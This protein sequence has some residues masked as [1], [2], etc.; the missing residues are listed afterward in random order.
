[1]VRRL[2]IVAGV[3][4][5]ASIGC[6]TTGT[7]VGGPHNEEAAAGE[8]PGVQAPKPAERLTVAAVQ[9]RSTPDLDANV[10]RTIEFIARCAEHG[11]R[12]V[13]FP[14]CNVTM[15][16]TETATGATAEELA[17]AERRIGEA[18]REHNV[19]AIVGMPWRDGGKLFNSAIILGPDGG[20]I[21]RYHKVQLAED[22]P[23]PGDHL[24]IY[25]IDGVWCTTIVCHD[26]RYP[27]L[28]RLPVLCGARVVFYISH[29]SGIKKESKIGPYRA[30]IQARA[31]E[32]TVYVI[33][34]NA[35]A[36]EDVSGSNGHS[37]IIAPDG[38]MVQEASV[39]GEDVLIAELDLSRATGSLAQKS[40]RSDLLRHWWEA[41]MQHVRRVEPAAAP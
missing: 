5:G 13:V 29:E 11:A 39:F 10:A 35:P 6:S 32:N 26:E 27:E 31:V 30:Q 37:R 9:M 24:S 34:A 2:L 8:R 17:G 19:Y 40:L 23:D 1:M 25:P 38:N 33:Q 16:A 15:Y 41:G 12:V 18:C 36:N 4:V 3:V 28:V 7:T 22:W 20:V 14:E 21:E